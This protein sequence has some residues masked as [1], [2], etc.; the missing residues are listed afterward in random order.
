MPYRVRRTLIATALATLLAGVSDSYAAHCHE[1]SS[2]WTWST[3][4]NHKR[5]ITLT[6][7]THVVV[8][9]C[10]FRRSDARGV[11]DWE[12]S[13]RLRGDGYARRY[14]CK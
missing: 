4:G 8:G 6:D 13:P 11:I 14:G 7:G 3:M 5:G 10:A 12:R 9:P 2:C 1:D